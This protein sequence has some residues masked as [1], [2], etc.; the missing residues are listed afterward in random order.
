MD[1]E[2]HLGQERGKGDQLLFFCIYTKKLFKTVICSQFFS[3]WRDEILP[4]L[5]TIAPMPEILLSIL[6]SN[7]PIN[8]SSTTSL[9]EY[10]LNHVQD[11]TN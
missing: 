4:P 11:D 2:L 8:N 1:L 7:K 3:F 5:P 6:K 10:D 9:I